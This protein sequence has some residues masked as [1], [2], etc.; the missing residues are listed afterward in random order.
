[1]ES[2]DEGH[3]HPIYIIVLIICLL[4]FS[5]VLLP[6]VE[7][8]GVGDYPVPDEGDWLIQNDTYVHDENIHLNGSITIL[9]NGTLTLDNV[10]LTL[11]SS[12]SAVLGIFV[13][14]GGTLNIYHSDITSSNGPYLF[15]VDGYMTMESS[16]ISRLVLGIAI[17][18]G[19]V[20]IAN[21]TIYNND[22]YAIRCN[23]SPVLKNNHIHSNH[24]G[25]LISWGGAPLL[26]N[27]TISSNEWGVVCLAI[28]YGTLIGNDISDN[29]QGGITVELGHFEIHNNTIYSN[30][31]FG[32]TS[33]HASINATNN[34]IYD[35]ERWGIYSWGAPIFH[36]DNTF[37]KNGKYNKEGD[38]LQV[39]DVLIKIF[40]AD[41][42][43]LENV[44]LTIYDSL[45]DIIWRGNTIGN[46]RTVVLR[47]YEL[48][49]DRTEVVHTPFTIKASKEAY[50]NSTIVDVGSNTE[51][52]IVIDYREK[53]EEPE[54]TIPFWGLVALGGI[55]I[56]I[57]IFILVGL[58]ITL[59]NRKRKNI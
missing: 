22:Q 10:T 11:N 44:N 43:S 55:W 57:I 32:I 30:G 40:D 21:S 58:I 39:W 14:V 47:E 19:D 7:A 5:I 50:F 9:E 16:I 3:V 1:M 31:G 28:G 46:I 2:L 54:D 15:N 27:N 13:K 36:K 24:G 48:K 49:N 59:R 34:T 12:S 29:A 8:E 42:Q 52:I 41:N 6:N 35:N 18:Y 20:T 26:S 45:G 17:N 23:G 25:I 37:E 4:N 53:E 56:V 38:V 33:D 51:I